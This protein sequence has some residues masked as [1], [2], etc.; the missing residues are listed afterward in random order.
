[1]HSQLLS[2]WR[3]LVGCLPL[4]KS[5]FVAGFSAKRPASS[6]VSIRIRCRSQRQHRLLRGRRDS[7]HRHAIFHLRPSASTSPIAGRARCATAR[8]CDPS[9]A[10][11]PQTRQ[12]SANAATSDR[13]LRALLSSKFRALLRRPSVT[14]PPRASTADPLAEYSPLIYY[15][16]VGY[17]T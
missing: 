2:N 10:L 3:T 8:E 9:T 17:S 4:Q 6:T 1:M 5:D 11:P 7:R 12:Q 16:P 15:R 13:L 14:A